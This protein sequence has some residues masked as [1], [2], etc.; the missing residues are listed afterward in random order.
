MWNAVFSGASRAR[1]FANSSFWIQ[2]QTDETSKSREDL[3]K[4]EQ[5]IKTGLAGTREALKA[6]HKKKKPFSV[7]I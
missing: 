2:T 3:R 6:G 7:L 5:T 1:S 4:I